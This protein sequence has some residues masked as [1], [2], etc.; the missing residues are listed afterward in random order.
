MLFANLC[1][2]IKIFKQTAKMAMLANL[3]YRFN[4]IIDSCVQPLFSTIV[5][6]ALWS[7]L[8][9]L[10]KVDQLGGFSKASYL[11]YMLW[12]SFFSRIAA[13][14]MYEMRM[15]K[16]VESGAINSVLT[17]PFTFYEF[18]CGQFLG[19]KLLTAFVSFLIPLAVKLFWDLPIFYDRLPMIIL[20]M[21]LNL[22]FVYTISFCISSL[23]FFFTR[24]TSVTVTKNLVLW[25]I[26]GEIFPLD[27]FPE[28][29]RSLMIRSPFAAGCYIP[30]G[31]LTGRVESAQFYESFIS[32]FFGIIVFLLIGT[33]F[34]NIGVKKYSGIGA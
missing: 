20:L 15:I 4:F 24:V 30:V 10:M 23:A 8:F 14:W 9:Q 12:A 16:E 5:D 28:F 22:F 27:L 29:I 2:T 32:L 1:R 25:L 11:S 7:S 31:Y 26:S 17:R 3:E 33:T 21:I 19:Y 34:W 13:N 18:Y 6:L